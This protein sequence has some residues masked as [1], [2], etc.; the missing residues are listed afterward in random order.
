MT[1]QVPEPSVIVY[2]EPELVHAP[3]EVKVTAKPEVALATTA[4]LLP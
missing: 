1:M 2:R 4:K 3:E